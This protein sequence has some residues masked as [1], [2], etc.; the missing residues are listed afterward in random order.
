MSQPTAFCLWILCTGIL[1]LASWSV[2]SLIHHV[3]LAQTTCLPFVI[4]PCSLLGAPWQMAQ[5]IVV[6]VLKSLPARLT[7]NWLPFL[8][9]N[10]FWHNGYEPFERLGADTFLTASPG[11]LILYTC[12]ADVNVQL[13][14][15]GNFGK[16]VELMS[17]LNIYGPTITGTD[18]PESRLYR[19]IAGPFFSESTLRRVFAQSAGGAKIL[20]AALMRSDAHLQLQTLSA[21]LSLNTLCQIA[22]NYQTD[23][24][25]VRGLA[26]QDS[27]PDG[28][29]LSYSQA[30]HGLLKRMGVIFVV[31]HWMLRMSPFRSHRHAVA[32]YSELG[33]YMDQL[34]RA[35]QITI[36]KTPVH[37]PSSDEDLLDLLIQAGVSSKDQP[38]P[39]LTNRQVIGQIFLFM[40]AGHEANANLL[41]SIILILSCHPDIQNAMQ[42]DLDYL[43]GDTVP[44][45]WS[46]DKNYSELMHSTVGAVI[47]EALRLFTVIPVLPKCVPTDGPWLS[48]TVKGQPHPLPPGT[49][50]LSNTSATHRHPKY[51]PDRIAGMAQRQRSSWSDIRND[52]RQRPYAA[53]DFDPLRWL[54]AG[55]TDET[56]TQSA[57]ANFLKPRA[58]SFIPFSE[59][60]R[61]CLGRRF[62][63]VQVCA[64]VATLFKT[65]SVE[66]VTDWGDGDEDAWLKARR[67]AALALSEGTRFDTSLRSVRDVPIRFIERRI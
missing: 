40:F 25:L 8:L 59:G 15:D 7:R 18:G 67:C 63:L 42:R 66:L 39:L 21:R 35:R 36:S 13:F 33:S 54:D 43:L 32:C 1:S 55:S 47:N 52:A 44:E 45:A 46:Y 26:F 50:A 58:G 64:S 53:A 51:W 65:H 30:L 34:K 31:P 12:D 16:P 23:S 56:T 49:I 22:F 14:R 3:R 61:G 5:F 37:G 19:K 62:G 17:I 28:K 57:T 38:T 2:I 9:F 29:T 4:L 10:E 60:S 41:V 24:D 20:I 27:I 6:P 48:I 11:G